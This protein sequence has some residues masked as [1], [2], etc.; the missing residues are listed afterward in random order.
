MMD[1]K[2]LNIFRNYTINNSVV[3]LYDFPNVFRIYNKYNT[4]RSLP[5]FHM[6]VIP[7]CPESFM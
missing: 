3:T 4:L 5:Q 1:S 2:N 7:A 6:S